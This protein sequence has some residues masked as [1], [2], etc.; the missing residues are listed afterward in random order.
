MK[1]VLV[2]IFGSKYGTGDVATEQLR[3]KDDLPK[4]EPKIAQPKLESKPKPAAPVSAPEPVSV[5]ASVFLAG[6][7]GEKYGTGQVEKTK[8]RSKADLPEVSFSNLSV[9]PKKTQPV[10]AAPAPVSASIKTESVSSE[11]LSKL[12]GPSFGT[13][14]VSRAQH[15]SADYIPKLGEPIK[16]VKEILPTLDTKKVEI[17][18]EIA[19]GSVS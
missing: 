17:P 7:F 12:F 19:T 3:S 11:V 13:G 8:L 5:S 4:I 14:E 9:E 1:D 2:G 6:L 15:R 18:V 10:Q 16:C